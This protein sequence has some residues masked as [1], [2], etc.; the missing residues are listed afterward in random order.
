MEFVDRHIG[1]RH[2]DV[3]EML[4]ALGVSTL[5]ELIDKTVPAS[6]RDEQMDAPDALSEVEVLKK[7]RDIA[8]KNEVMS[9]L[10]GQGYY[11]TVTPAVIRRRLIES[12]AWYTAYTPYQPEISQ[13]RLEAL[14]NFQTMVADLTGMDIA[15]AS[16]LD[17]ATAAAEAMT[18]IHRSTKGSNGDRFLVDR[19]CFPQTIAV[20]ETRAD[21]LGLEIVIGDPAD[22]DDSFFGMIVQYPG[23]RGSIPD[24]KATIDNA[25]GSGVAVAVAADILALTLIEAPGTYGADVVVGSTQRFG[26]P[27]G[28]GGPHA[29]YMAVTDDLKRSMPGRLAGVSVDTEGR[30]ALRLALQTRE[31]HIR[32]ERATSNICT[33]QALLAIVSSMYAVYHGPDGLTDI[34]TRVHTKAARIA[35]SLAG[36]AHVVKNSSF[37]DTLE[38]TIDGG[39]TDFMERATAQRINV[40][41]LDSQTIGMSFDEV[42]SEKTLETLCE[43]FGVELVADAPSGI[44][45]SVA[46]TTEF[47]THPVFNVH[48]SETQLLRYMHMLASKDLALDRAMIPLGSCTMKLN[49]TAALEPISWPEFAYIHPFA[50]S[51]QT[52]GYQEIIADLERWLSSIT[53]YSAFSLQPNAGS[54][55]EFAGLLAIAAYHRSRGDD[56]RNVC[57]IPASAHGT[58]PAS[59]VMAGMEVVVVA[60]TAMG[61]IDLDDLRA[62]AEQ[63]SASLA[64]IMITYP[65][66]NGVFEETVGEVCQIVHD[67]G[68]QVYVDGA[69]LNALVGLAKPGHFGGDVSHLNLHKTFSIPHGGGGPGIGPIGVGAHLAP[70]LP[71]HPELDLGTKQGPVSG[72]P[73]GSAGVLPVPWVYIHMLGEA[74]LRRST[75]V[76]I[77]NA[78]YIAKRLSDAYPVLYTGTNGF[79]AHECIIDIRPITHDSGVTVDDIAKRL[80]DYGF[81]AP[82]MSFPV[83][84]TLMIEPTE[85]ESKQELDRFI[86]AMLQIR[87]EIAEVESGTVSVEES[88]LRHAPH[89]ARDMMTEDWDRA[90]PRM[91]GAYPGSAHTGRKYWPPVSRIDGGYGDRHLVCS[92]VPIEDYA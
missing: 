7:L 54:Q 64:A 34:A 31:Q 11:S 40:R 32:R 49:A 75:E 76:A 18:L 57:L 43:L 24:L 42:T 84:G 14:L 25:H 81:H 53:G 29:G 16:L 71:G 86:D 52:G 83:A 62:K 22:I 30:P 88:V 19:A 48:H 58:N 61:E 3:D 59:A 33:A 85:S 20:L 69:N 26:V 80:I 9:S 5:G 2:A 68:G 56:H 77:L 27:L 67:H 63:H 73:Y 46:R 41:Y 70:F 13:G 36:S 45:G 12:P 17:E 38:V 44:P 1:P 74:G 92:C 6:I 51:D 82:T 87:D 66:T 65:S 89:P 23:E 4:I 78:N 28:F 47:L 39:A 79:V 21:P 72:A 37:F 8:A 35:A 60:T 90:Y 91:Q 15:N 10:I 50:P 55:G